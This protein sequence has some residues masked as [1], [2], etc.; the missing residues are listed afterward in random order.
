MRTLTS[1]VLS[2]LALPALAG[3]PSDRLT[4]D[5]P[6]TTVSGNTFIA[7]QGWS[8]RV[9]GPA[10]IVEAPEGESWIALVDVKA[11]DADAAVAAAW[12]AYKPV[13]K[14]ETKWAVKV[15]TE[16]P[17]RDGWTKQRFYEYVTSP[18]ERRDV[19]ASTRFANGA[20]LVAIYDV[21]QPV[22]EKRGAQISLVFDRL[23]PKGYSRETFAG[24][25]A[26][27]LDAARLGAISRFVDEGRKEIRIPGVAVGIVEDGRVLF[28]GGFGE[29]EIGGGAAPDG[30]TLFMIASNTKALT[31]LLLAKEV[32]GK[33]LTWETP[34]TSLLPSFKLG[35]ADTTKRVL[36]KHLIC[37]CTG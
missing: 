29:K 17:D 19:F 23:F 31:T 36:V 35:D 1:L 2:V 22:G 34:V 8:V 20:W 11:A 25:K 14:H 21:S 13:A 9:S 37:A 4:A 5:T 3:T 30:D 7:P 32:E 18:N 24:K 27:K 10:T 6:K 26:H 12:A 16:R 33:K 15:A 28:S